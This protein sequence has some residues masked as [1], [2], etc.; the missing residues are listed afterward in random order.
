MPKVRFIRDFDWCP[1]AGVIVAF[2]AGMELSVTRAA[3]A[4]AVAAGAAV[5]TG[6]RPTT[7]GKDHGTGHQLQA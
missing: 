2:R 1:R 3:A 4:K 7:K 6:R 5:K